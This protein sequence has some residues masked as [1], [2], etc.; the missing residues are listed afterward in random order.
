MPCHNRV[1][2][3]GLFLEGRSHRSP[4][5]A[6]HACAAVPWCTGSPE[7]AQLRHHC[8]RSDWATAT[9]PFSL[10]DW[11]CSHERISL[12]RAHRQCAR[13][14]GALK[15]HT[16]FFHAE[17]SD[18]DVKLH[19]ERGRGQGSSFSGAKIRGP[20][21]AFLSPPFHSTAPHYLGPGVRSHGADFAARH[22]TDSNI[23]GQLLCRLIMHH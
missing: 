14:T 4:P 9:G 8:F 20:L 17:P 7:P 13:E 10:N 2:S 15:M 23:I 5:G 18:P 12:T 1:P 22:C 6:L 16:P 11:L 19:I 21:L 3:L